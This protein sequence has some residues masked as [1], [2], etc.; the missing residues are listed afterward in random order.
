MSP[1]QALQSIGNLGLQL[2]QGKEPWMAPLHAILL[3]S[4]TRVKA[5]LDS[6]VAVE[7]TE[8]E[9]TRWAPQGHGG[10]CWHW[11]W[12][13]QHPAQRSSSIPHIWEHPGG[14]GPALC[15]RWA[16]SGWGS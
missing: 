2:G 6:L 15:H 9:R 13:C 8:G 10:H 4:V 12:P 1:S 7:S 11:V 5:F 16:S 14:G 3:P